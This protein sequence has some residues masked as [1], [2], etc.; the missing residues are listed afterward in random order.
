[1]PAACAS[2]IR[3][4]HAGPRKHAYGAGPPGAP[5]LGES[6]S[7]QRV[8][9]IDEHDC[10][11]STT[12]VAAVID[13]HRNRSIPLVLRGCAAGLPA[14]SRWRSNGYL[15]AKGATSNFAALLGGGDGYD[16]AALDA[17][18]AGDL[19]A[20]QKQR[21]ALRDFSALLLE[22]TSAPEV[23][24]PRAAR[25]RRC[26]PTFDNLHVVI[27]GKKLLPRLATVLEKMYVDYPPLARPDATGDDNEC[28]GQ[29]SVG[30]DELGCFTYV[31]FDADRVDLTGT[32]ACATPPSATRWCAR[33]HAVH[34]GAVVPPHPAPPARRA[35]RPRGIALTFTR[36]RRCRSCCRLP[37]ASRAT[38]AT[39]GCARARHQRRL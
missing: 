39:V 9:A 23:W 1:M 27:S 35:R 2:G 33:R 8:D 14:I 15:R 22:I 31:P 29:G 16:V 34:P 10:A 32:R 12:D 11:T 37:P 4:L 38:G 5:S 18:L 13:A 25:S 17:S 20:D 21:R 36:Q 3:A 24:T 19:V 30:C 26:T 6:I 7:G 28:P